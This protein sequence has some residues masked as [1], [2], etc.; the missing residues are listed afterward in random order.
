MPQ[1]VCMQKELQWMGRRKGR[2]QNALQLKLNNHNKSW[3]EAKSLNQ[4]KTRGKM[5][6]FFPAAFGEVPIAFACSFFYSEC[7][8]QLWCVIQQGL[9][10]SSNHMQ[11]PRS[12]NRLTQEM[13]RKTCLWAHTF[14]LYYMD[15][16]YLYPQKML[17]I[18]LLAKTYLP[19]TYLC[20]WSHFCTVEN[21][22]P[23]WDKR[24]E[25]ILR[26]WTHML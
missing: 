5:S 13:R 22:N 25:K 1:Q 7:Q 3:L 18:L 24:A 6:Q 26:A 15:C 17:I 19:A 16:S 10:F 21:T 4:I 12:H 20:V 14:F 23:L 8:L 2:G 9:S 11:S